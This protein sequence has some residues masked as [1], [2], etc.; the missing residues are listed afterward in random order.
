[1]PFAAM[2]PA[3]HQPAAG[4]T[5]GAAPVLRFE[6]AQVAQALSLFRAALDKVEPLMQQAQSKLEMKPMARD[7]V[8]VEVAQEITKK[9]IEGKTSALAAITG[10]HQQLK[11]IVEQLEAAA[12]QYG[13]ADERSSVQVEGHRA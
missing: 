13:I 9:G 11:T 3:G 8:S 10:Y 6:P 5:P 4:A 2:G 12:R 1:M 7:D